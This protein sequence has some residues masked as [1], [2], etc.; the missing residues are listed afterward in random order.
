M[1]ASSFKGI[2]TTYYGKCD[3]HEDGSYVTTKWF[4]FLGV[5]L[6]PICSHRVIPA[7]HGDV[8]VPLIYHSEGYAHLDTTRPHLRQVLRIYL[9][10]VFLIFVWLPLMFFISRR[11]DDGPYSIYLILFTLAAF[12][13]P[14]LIPA[15]LRLWARRR[16]R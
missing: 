11:V 16:A 2:G 12:G 6:F 3:F 7:E 9:F 14:C 10:M 13:L 8:F 4:I 1:G 15:G 5:P